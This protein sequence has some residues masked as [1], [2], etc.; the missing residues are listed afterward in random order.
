MTGYG[1]SPVGNVRSCPIADKMLQCRECPL[2]AI[3]R[4][5]FISSA[6]RQDDRLRPDLAFT[7]RRLIVASHL[8]EPIKILSYGAR[9]RPTRGQFNGYGSRT[10]NIVIV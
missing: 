3:T 1:I 10:R 5:S 2:N 4:P 7:C 6:M 9:K 8:E